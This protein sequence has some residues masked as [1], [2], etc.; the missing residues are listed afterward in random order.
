MWV[1]LNSE[2]QT[3]SIQPVSYERER[4]A[5]EHAYFSASILHD[6]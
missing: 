5:R 6:L 4:N 1:D 3:V 2:L